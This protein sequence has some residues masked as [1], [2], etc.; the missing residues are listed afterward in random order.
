MDFTMIAATFFDAL[1]PA[2]TACL[3][4]PSSITCPNGGMTCSSF[5]ASVPS[6]VF[7]IDGEKFTVP[8]QAYLYDEVITEISGASFNMCYPAL[9]A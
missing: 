4:A 9:S 1:T 2:Q 6:F 7:T 5:Y 3:Q 8:S